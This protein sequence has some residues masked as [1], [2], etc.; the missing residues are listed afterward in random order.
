MARRIEKLIAHLI[1]SIGLSFILFFGTFTEV[2]NRIIFIERVYDFYENLLE[3][4]WDVF[5][6]YYENDFTLRNF[7]S[8]Y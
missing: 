1:R 8:Q 4:N 2:V 3:A 6:T 7:Y 5:I